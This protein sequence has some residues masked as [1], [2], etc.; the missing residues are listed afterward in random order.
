[1]QN[2]KQNSNSD[3]SVNPL[4]ILETKPA[5]SQNSVCVNENLIVNYRHDLPGELE[6]PSGITHHFI[7][8]F[9]TE[10]KRQ[11]T[12]LNDSGE[13]DGQMNQG[14]FYLC[15]AE[16]SGFTRW[17]AVDETL[18]LAIKPSLIR[19]I[20]L[21]TESLNPDKI[22]LLPVLKDY[23]SQIEQ[24]AK[25]LFSEI[26][27]DGLGG[28]LYLES[29]ANVLIIHLL[30]NYCA[31]EPV[32]RNYEKGLSRHKLRQIIDYIHDYL[33]QDLSLKVMAKEIDMSHAYFAD[34]FKQAMGI[35]PHQYV[36]QQ[37]IEKAK[38]LLKEQK[39]TLAEIALESGLSS[40]S[41]LNKL[42][43]KYVGVTQK[44]YQ[45]QL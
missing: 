30:R 27:N 41:H 35:S 6:I 5:I 34:Q 19:R 43:R 45:K 42:F 38:Q 28:K 18:H 11:I 12:H 39:H 16:V 3:K 25:L 9:L 26:Q 23:D 10:N 4:D 15:P 8:F 32:F 31:S 40:Q 37:R 1:M 44:N 22:E 36:N 21:E 7:T 29:L 2:R 14:E 24:L 13:Y 17:E 33:D 20:A